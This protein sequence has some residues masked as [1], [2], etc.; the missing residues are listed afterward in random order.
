MMTPHA[1]LAIFQD[2]GQFRFAFPG[3]SANN[4]RTIPTLRMLGE[5]LRRDGADTVRQAVCF[6]QYDDQAHNEMCSVAY[7]KRH[8]QAPLVR[9]IPDTYFY[10]SRGYQE[11]RGFV[12]SGQCRAWSLREP[13]IF[14]RGSPT[15]RWHRDDGTEIASV[16]EIPRVRLCEL[17][18]CDPRADAGL[19]GAWGDRFAHEDMLAYFAHGR[20]LRPAVKMTEHANYRYQIDIDGVANA[21]GFFDKLLMGSCILKVESPYRQWFYDGIRAWEHYVPVS[22]DLS[23]LADRVDW[24]F[25]NEA[26]A[27]RIAQNG[28]AFALGHTF[29]A[30]VKLTLEAFSECCIPLPARSS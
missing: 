25:A 1:T 19:V 26:Q 17:L 5:L 30:A 24:C 10:F 29:E 23:D 18:A 22:N 21:W 15:T 27:Q 6:V 13:M 16:G 2:G 14:W 7:G 3:H 9:L 11:T 8:H 4:A 12:A 28:Q 20:I